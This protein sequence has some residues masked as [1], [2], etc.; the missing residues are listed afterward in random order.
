MAKK[1]C[2]I[3]LVKPCLAILIR[4]IATLQYIEELYETLCKT[5]A[6]K[7]WEAVFEEKSEFTNRCCGVF[8][9]PVV[10]SMVGFLSCA[11]RILCFGFGSAER[12]NDLFSCAEPVRECYRLSHPEHVQECYCPK[13]H[14]ASPGVLIMINYVIKQMT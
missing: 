12:Y 10:Y 1:H 5:Y 8:S 9:D 2:F 11:K 13:S 3:L 14:G 7:L 4:R 6:Q